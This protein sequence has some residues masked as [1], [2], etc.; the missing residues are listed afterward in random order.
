MQSL[1]PAGLSLLHLT[2]HPLSRPPQ[3]RDELGVLRRKADAARRVRM[4]GPMGPR[5]NAA[6]RRMRMIGQARKHN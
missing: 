6:R 5:P 2:C 4:A 1:L 3:V